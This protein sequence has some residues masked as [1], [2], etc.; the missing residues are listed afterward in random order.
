MPLGSEHLVSFTYERLP[1]FCYL[2]GRLGHIG[3]Y[4][5]LAFAEGFVDP[6]NDTPYGPWLRAPAHKPSQNIAGTSEVNIIGTLGRQTGQLRGKDIFGS[7]EHVRGSSKGAANMEPR[8]EGQA[9]YRGIDSNSLGQGKQHKNLGRGWDRDGCLEVSSESAIPETGKETDDRPEVGECNTS[10]Q[11]LNTNEKGGLD[12]SMDEEGQH[13]NGSPRLADVMMGIDS[14]YEQLP[15]SDMN[16]IT[17]PLQFAATRIRQVGR[18]R[19]RG[20]RARGLLPNTSRKRVSGTRIIDVDELAI[21]VSKRRH[22][23]DDESDVIS[24]ETAVQSRQEP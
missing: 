22:L 10:N 6:G 13:E 11:Y 3:K 9:N 21:Q 2:C 15:S 18:P 16:L 24:A 1:N 14:N 7:F 20:R 19:G 23:I 17:I 5:E 4:C 8:T 12:S